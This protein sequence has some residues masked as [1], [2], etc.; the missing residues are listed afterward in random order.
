MD[1][2]SKSDHIWWIVGIAFVAAWCLYLAF[3][4]PKLPEGGLAPPRL[5]PD[6][7][8]A[9]PA[10]YGWT[11]LDLDDNPVEFAK[12]KG[13]PVF[14][15]IW[16][17][18]CPPCVAELPSI[19]NLAAN[20]RVKDVTFIC[21]STDQSADKVKSFLRDKSWPMTVLRATDLPE[22]F[23]T[24]GIPATFLIAP[25]GKVA[26]AEVGSAQWDDPSA[27]AFLEKLAKQPPVKP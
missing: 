4:G 18:W 15:N 25:D 16:A 26:I 27:V 7:A 8:L 20:P 17:T 22:V 14:L 6:S 1:T 10:D 24:D 21:V 12:F 19:A 2:Q 3:F 9:R 13:K 11:L 5:S 23:V